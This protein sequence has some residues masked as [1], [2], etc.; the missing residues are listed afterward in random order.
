[1]PPV[2][3]KANPVDIEVGHRIRLHR[4]NAK[5]SQEKLGDAIGVTFQQVQKYEKG[6]NRVGASRLTQIATALRVAVNVFFENMPEASERNDNG[7]SISLLLTTPYA[8]RLL[9][10]YAKIGNSK[11]RHSV[12]TMV[13]EMSEVPPRK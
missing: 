8:L 10:G 12:V 4:M 13:E 1:M 9:Q 3:K 2:K 7:D 5:I 6:V 11:L